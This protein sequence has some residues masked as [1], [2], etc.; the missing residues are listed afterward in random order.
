MNILISDFESIMRNDKFVE[1]IKDKISNKSVLFIP[2]V[3]EMIDKSSKYINGIINVFRE[4]NIE[5]DIIN[6]FTNK[7]YSNSYLTDINKYGL[8]F[9]MGGRTL[10]Q[11]EIL[12]KYNFKEVLNS[13]KGV[14]IGMSAGALNMCNDSILTPGDGDV[15]ETF[16]FKGLGL[17]NLTVDVH[18]NPSDT[19]H[20][21][22]L[23][24][25]NKKIYCI[26]DNGAIIENRGSLL[27]IG[28]IYSYKG[29]NRIIKL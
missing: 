13:Y 16:E 2:S 15:N 9:L 7:P 24:N 17:V 23:K 4:H 6:H 14:V 21:K 10:E 3:I 20:I 11:N 27:M 18:F 28:D 19:N 26:T 8:I 22:H 25:V 12:S 1:H 29:N 5:F